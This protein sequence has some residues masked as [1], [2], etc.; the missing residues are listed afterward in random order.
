MKKGRPMG[1][2]Q[3]EFNERMFTVYSLDLLRKS[4]RLL[5]AVK[6][7]SD[8]MTGHVPSSVTDPAVI[9]KRFGNAVKYLRTL[10]PEDII[11]KKYDLGSIE[12]IYSDVIKGIDNGLIDYIDPGKKRKKHDKNK[13]GYT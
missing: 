7:V 8:S 10:P 12:T 9:S 1:E 13:I 4:H 2:Q 3:K 5:V 11:R 6:T